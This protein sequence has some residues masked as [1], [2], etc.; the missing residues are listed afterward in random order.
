MQYVIVPG[1]RARARAMRELELDHEDASSEM[2]DEGSSDQPADEDIDED[3]DEE[4]D[5]EEYDDEE[6][7]DEEYDDEEYDD[8]EYEEYDDEEYDSEDGDN[9]PA[10]DVGSHVGV[11]LDGEDYFGTIVEFNDDEGTV[12]IEEDGTGD[13][14]EADQDSMFLE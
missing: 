12:T 11:E 9:E 3:I 6:Y 13:L 5:D 4:Y 7:D 14:I 8:E 10:I 1:W 2:D